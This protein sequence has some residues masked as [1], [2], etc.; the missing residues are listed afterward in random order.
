M[1]R[2]G[3]PAN[4]SASHTSRFIA[5]GCKKVRAN[6]QPYGCSMTRSAFA[7]W[8][9]DAPHGAPIDRIATLRLDGR[10]LR[11]DDT[12]ARRATVPGF[13]IDD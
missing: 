6:F 11:I 1:A 7:G 3:T 5:I 9:K 4:E 2:R 13:C 8:F 10:L 12:G